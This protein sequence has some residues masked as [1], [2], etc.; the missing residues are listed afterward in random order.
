VEQLKEEYSKI[1]KM[2]QGTRTDLT[3]VEIQTNVRTDER[4]AKELGIGGKDTFHKAEY[5]YQ[6]A[7]EDI[8]KAL[9]DKKLSINKAY[10][11][12]KQESEEYKQKEILRV[13]RIFDNIKIVDKY[14]T[15][16]ELAQKF[17]LKIDA[18]NLI[19]TTNFM[20]KR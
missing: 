1:A 13:V 14:Y 17:G 9:D 2:N 20:E 5:I 4:V 18:K 3:S 19:R 7:D 12:L 11:K 15:L 6:N 8:I 10:I 16:I